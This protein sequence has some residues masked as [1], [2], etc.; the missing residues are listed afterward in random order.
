MT[1]VYRCPIC[2]KDTD[3]PLPPTCAPWCSGPEGTHHKEME[4]VPEKS[5]KVPPYLTQKK[6]TSKT[7]PTTPEGEQS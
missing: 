2:K 5:S 1:Y 3:Q 4:F 7:Q 6:K